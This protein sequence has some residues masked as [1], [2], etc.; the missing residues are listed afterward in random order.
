M[1]GPIQQP[2]AGPRAPDHRSVRRL[3]A[4]VHP[5]AAAIRLV[6]LILL[7]IAAILAVVPSA[8]AMIIG[9]NLLI[10]GRLGIG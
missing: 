1:A 7:P 6:G 5:R 10:L 2:A 4:A 8:L 3:S 9:L